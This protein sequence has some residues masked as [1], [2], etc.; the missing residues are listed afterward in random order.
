MTK[1][2]TLYHT[3]DDGE[4]D[5]T[6]LR[7]YGA[8][9]KALREIGIEQYNWENQRYFLDYGS[10]LA[11]FNS[12]ISQLPVDEIHHYDA[13]YSYDTELAKLA[14]S[15][16]NPDKSYLLSE[17]PTD[18]YLFGSAITVFQDSLDKRDFYDSL[19]EFIDLVWIGVICIRCSSH[20][21]RS[22]ETDLYIPELSSVIDAIYSCASIKKIYIKNVDGLEDKFVIAF[23][24]E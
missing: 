20:M 8:S 23:E 4:S 16:I 6:K 24:K 3:C 21:I 18:K 22:T 10:G 14:N 15:N 7:S 1:F 17:F 11:K 9:I 5:N 13:R 12:F 19:R 2:K